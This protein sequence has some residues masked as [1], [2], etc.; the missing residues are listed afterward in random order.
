MKHSVVIGGAGF[1]G[2]WVVD[3]ILKDPSARVTIV[4]NLISSEKW[5]ILLDPRVTFIEG[6]AADVNVLKS[7]K[8]KVDYVYQL[9]C[10]H[11]NQSSI[12]RPL[13]DF[14]NGLKTTLVSLEWVKN[15]NPQ[16]RVVYSGAG[17]AVAE[18]TW[19]E[20]TAVEEKEFSSL[21][22][23]SPYSISKIA[24][25]MYCLYYAKQQNIDVVRVRFQNVYGPREILGAG[26]WRGTIDSIW[27]NVIPTFIW[28]S[29][30]NEDI[31]IFGTTH[32]SRDFVY[33]GD[34]ANG[35]ILAAKFGKQGHVYNLARGEEVFISDLAQQIIA[36]TNSKSSLIYK[37]KRKWDTS[38]RRFGSTK[39]SLDELNFL[40]RTDL[41]SGLNSTV[42][43][44]QKNIKLI[45]SSI[46]HQSLNLKNPLS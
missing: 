8:D 21:L 16:A 14:E 28:K 43:W 31:T 46:S 6:S 4:D 11:G 5:N 39:K 26:A 32:A 45:S 23:D 3:E 42:Q 20:P 33:V 22:H 44:T 15:F 41:I 24:G 38:G 17:C 19:D 18:K 30:N 7:I 37:P 2:S 36:I 1:V 13:D 10:F 25:E 35:V 27:R 40:A 9:A 12:A 34:I 29:L